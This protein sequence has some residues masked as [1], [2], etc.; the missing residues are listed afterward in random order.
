[1]NSE[2]HV[3]IKN[4]KY[5]K[6]LFSL[7]ALILATDSCE[8]SKNAIENNSKIVQQALS[9]SYTIS[10]IGDNASVSQELMITFDE[11][12]DRVTGFAGCN[13]FFGTYVVKDNTI[14][15]SNIASSKKLCQKDINLVE[16]QLLNA[17]D[18]VN[19]F[20]IRDTVLTFLED[21]NTLL[22]AN[23]LV[24][25]NQSRPTNKRDIIKGNYNAL[26]VTY[27]A[28]S[29]GSF[30]YIHITKAQLSYSTD[31]GLKK[32]SHHNYDNQDWEDLSL[33][34]DAVDKV[35]FEK[36]KAPTDK[37]LYDGAAHATLAIINGDTEIMTPTFDDGFPPKEIEDLVN[38]V[39][40]IKESVVKQ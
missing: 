31:P 21:D 34:I 11:N 5:M 32:L 13:S 28:L 40:S 22:N 20:T 37:R 24:S 18:K 23:K 39:L 7:F 29:R 35:T 33:L 30:V 6:F 8:S 25:V 27:K 12:S 16:S 26:G 38:K 14:K 4:N 36:L 10:Q 1:M 3:T 17:L 9:G 19:S 2:L 15:F